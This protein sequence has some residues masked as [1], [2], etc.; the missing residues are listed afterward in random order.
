MKITY[1]PEADVLYIQFND[2]RPNDSIDIEPGIHY[3]ID[4]EGH[5]VGLEII[6]A[7]DK[8]KDFNKIEFEHYAFPIKKQPK[9]R[10]PKKQEATA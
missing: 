7:S 6:Y 10:T 5:L 9:K 8:L 1:D 4:K 2:N 3:E